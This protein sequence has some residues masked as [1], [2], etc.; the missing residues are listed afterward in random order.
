MKKQWLFRLFAVAAVLI[1]TISLA[2]AWPVAAGET[3]SLVFYDTPHPILSDTNVRKALAYC[4]DRP[5]LIAA[6]YPLL[7]AAEQSSLLMDTFIPTASYFYDNATVKYPYDPTQ[8]ES[9]LAASGWTLAPG[10]TYRKKDGK[11]LV[12]NFYST[13]AGLRIAYAALLEQQWQACGVHLVRYHLVGRTLFLNNGVLQQRRF[14]IASFAWV[15][16]LDPDGQALYACDFIPRPSNNW[17]GLNYMGWCEPPA[18]DA[19]T[20][21]VHTV[22]RTER[23]ADYATVQ[24]YFAD[25]M[26]SLPLFART[27]IDVT[28]AGFTGLNPGP[29][30][31]YYA[32]NASQW[33]VPG[34]TTIQWGMVN[35]D[36]PGSLWDLQ[37]YSGAPF[38]L[39]LINSL[40]NTTLNYDLQPILLD[41]M[42]TLD[43]GKATNNTVTVSTGTLVQDAMGN[44]VTLA[45]GMLIVNASGDEVTFTGAPVDMKQLAV[46]YVFKPNIKWSDGTTLAAEDFTLF[47]RVLCDLPDYDL[48]YVCLKTQTFAAI[49]N[50]YSVT[51]I[52]GAQ[53]PLYSIPPYLWYP[54]HRIIQSGGPYHGMRLDQVPSDQWGTLPEVTQNPIGVGPYVLANWNPGVSMN[55][56]ANPYFVLGAPATANITIHFLDPGTL[57]SQLLDGTLHIAGFESIGSV[58]QALRDADTAGTIDVTVLPSGTWEHLDMNLN[59]FFYRYLPN[60][61]KK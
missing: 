49:L 42:P 46:Q 53:N 59:I 7:T 41:G 4:T 30:Q 58:D 10:D 35:Y 47:K 1:L 9:L 28:K 29:G 54:A 24:N 57:E 22:D 20:H 12:I 2:G 45:P 37:G 26:V 32:Y 40:T 11:E 27:S 55:F 25:D 48:N 16:S 61:S 5:A 39:P 44:V 19:I 17:S 52:P 3:Q 15:S 31:D 13:A 34:Q 56:T 23:I 14:D 38:I 6:A 50:G 8:G 51:Y 60:I 36:E 33:A 18:S 21:A 43:N